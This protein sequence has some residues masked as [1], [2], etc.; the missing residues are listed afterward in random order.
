MLIICTLSC[1]S[2]LALN[3]SLNKFEKPL[4]SSKG[5]NH[6]SYKDAGIAER[7]QIVLKPDY[8]V[9]NQVYKF[10]IY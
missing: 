6:C 1:S 5:A 10:E 8:T 2:I 7:L 9:A 3:L 4:S